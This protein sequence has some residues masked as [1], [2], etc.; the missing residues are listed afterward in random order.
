MLLC[1]A[2]LLDS[3]ESSEYSEVSLSLDSGTIDVYTFFE[4]PGSPIVDAR[5][6]KKDFGSRL[7]NALQTALGVGHCSKQPYEMV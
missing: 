2:D 7:N 3:S 6:A 5:S 1:F 4:P